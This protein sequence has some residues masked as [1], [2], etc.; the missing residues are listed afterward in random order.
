MNPSKC[1]HC[2]GYEPF[3]LQLRCICG[4]VDL[5]CAGCLHLVADNLADGEPPEPAHQHNP[6]PLYLDLVDVD[7]KPH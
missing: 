5:I 2:N 4:K 7:A 3:L 6:L 1:S